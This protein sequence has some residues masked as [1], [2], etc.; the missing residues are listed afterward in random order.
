MHLY[1]DK[2]WLR[3]RPIGT[4]RGASVCRGHGVTTT[5]RPSSARWQKNDNDIL[6]VYSA[7]IL[8]SGGAAFQAKRIG[9]KSANGPAFTPCRSLF[10]RVDFCGR[11]VG[12]SSVASRSQRV[13]LIVIPFCLSVCLDVCRSFRDLQ[14]TTIDRSQ[15]NLVGTYT[16]CSK[17]TD[18][19]GYFDDNFGKYGPILII[20]SLLQ[21]E[22]HN[23][24]KLSYF[25]HLTFIMMPLYLAKQTLMLVS[26]LHV[27]FNELNGP[28][29]DLKS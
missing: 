1:N 13:S 24:Q 17:K 16:G 2:G 5:R 11:S 14:P 6:T 3:E 19:L 18:P 12:L 29:S 26:V 7:L 9:D 28:Q 8:H 10:V 4:V 22:I 23:A 15:P 20:F 25:S 21:Q 27:C